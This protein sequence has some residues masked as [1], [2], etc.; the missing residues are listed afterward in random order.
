[1]L[2]EMEIVSD[3]TLVGKMTIMELLHE[4]NVEIR[5]EVNLEEITD[6]GAVVSDKKGKRIELDADTVVLSL[7]VKSR[8]ENVNAFKD[9]TREVHVIGDCAKP[10][11]L[12]AAIH[13]AFNITAEI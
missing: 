8:Y 3:T 4:N 13:D 12:M 10:R 2:P 5:T 11:N 1:M 6:K 9:L 7:G